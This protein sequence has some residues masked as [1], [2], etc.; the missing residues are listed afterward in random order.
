MGSAMVVRMVLTVFNSLS[1][2]DT[3]HQQQTGNQTT[4]RYGRDTLHFTES[5]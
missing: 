3:P 4:D 5:D 2:Q 1:G